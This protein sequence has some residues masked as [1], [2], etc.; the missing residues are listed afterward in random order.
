[1]V[2]S[3]PLDRY[4][5]IDLNSITHQVVPGKAPRVLVGVT[6]VDTQY[7]P[8][9]DAACRALDTGDGGYFVGLPPEVPRNRVWLVYEGDDL[10]PTP[11][12]VKLERQMGADP[13]ISDW[14][15]GGIL[16]D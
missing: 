3:E 5:S 13:T 8:Q 9:I 2:V 12:T 4:S 1:M 15:S 7:T 16:A 10:T 14:S 6:Y 11:R